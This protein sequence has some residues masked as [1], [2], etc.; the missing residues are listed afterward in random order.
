MTANLGKRVRKKRARSCIPEAKVARDGRPLA[1]VVTRPPPARV[2]GCLSEAS[3]E[4]CQRVRLAVETAMGENTDLPYHYGDKTKQ[5]NLHRLDCCRVAVALVFRQQV[6]V[7]SHVHC[8]GCFAEPNLMR[9]K[10]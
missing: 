4:A 1:E 3:R 5:E 6:I 8:L 7:K 9:N 2:N 10:M